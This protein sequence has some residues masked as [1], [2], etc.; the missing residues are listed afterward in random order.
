MNDRD[1]GHLHPDLQPLCRA[2]LA[3]CRRQ[4][5]DAFVVFTWRSIAEQNRLYAKGR[6]VKS[7]IGPW[8]QSRPLGSKVTSARGNQ[9][10]HTFTLPDG[11][12]ASRAFDFGVLKNGLYVTDGADPLYAAAGRIG[13]RLGLTWGGRWPAPKTDYDHLQLS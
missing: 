1:T 4:N 8:T 7:D 2:W 13:E 3:E 5:I 9:S 12:P 10:L 11:T 6:T